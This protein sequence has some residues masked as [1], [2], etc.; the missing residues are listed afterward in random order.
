MM[1]M[2]N[3]MRHNSSAASA[4]PEAAAS[5]C[6]HI[7]MLLDLVMLTGSIFVSIITLIVL[8]LGLVRLLVT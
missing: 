3:Q 2:F 1:A 8:I 6:A 7:A 4:T 5:T